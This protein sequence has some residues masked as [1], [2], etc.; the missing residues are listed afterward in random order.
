M[1]RFRPHSQHEERKGCKKTV[2]ENLGQMFDRTKN[3]D[4]T[5]TEC[6]KSNRHWC[7]LNIKICVI[8]DIP[9]NYAILLTM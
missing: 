3:Y 6:K 5:A 7:E 9:Q 4:K 1:Q 8:I 2:K